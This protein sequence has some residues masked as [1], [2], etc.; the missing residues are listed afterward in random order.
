ME[1]FEKTKHNKNKDV[2]RKYSL[3]GEKINDILGEF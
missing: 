1:N 2:S 3:R